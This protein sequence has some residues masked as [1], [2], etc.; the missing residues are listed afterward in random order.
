MSIFRFIISQHVDLLV[1]ARHA[2]A[3]SRAMFMKRF[4]LPTI[5]DE[6]CPKAIVC[7]RFMALL[8]LFLIR[9]K[10]I[11]CYYNVF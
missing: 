11:L 8:N 3:C 5:H 10:P 6:N 7:T 1:N 4:L 2:M 9:F